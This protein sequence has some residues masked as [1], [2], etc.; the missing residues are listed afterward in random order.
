M[1]VQNATNGKAILSATDRLVGRQSAGAGISE[2]IIC[3]AA[4]RALID[5][6]DATAQRATLGLGTASTA[7]TGTAAGNI[8]VLDSNGQLPAS[9]MP[10]ISLTSV[11][12]VADQAARLAL[13]N[14][15]PGDVAKQ[16]D[17]GLS[18]I[19]STLP[20]SSN[21]NWISIGD[22]SIDASEIVSGIFG[23][24]STLPQHLC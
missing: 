1:A 23:K 13:A 24:R 16:S 8:A 19:L 18:Y 6:A 3:T 11:Q 4:G 7:N 22:T 14:V 5:D 21:A 2:E 20:A 9:T 12:V 10:S 15:Q 17:N